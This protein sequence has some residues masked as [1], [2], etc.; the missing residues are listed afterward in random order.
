MGSNGKT[1]STLFGGRLPEPS[2]D[3][4]IS[5][6]SRETEISHWSLLWDVTWNR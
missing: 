4:V 1:I 5:K 3:R 2:V 6:L